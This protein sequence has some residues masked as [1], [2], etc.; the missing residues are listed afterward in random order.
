MNFPTPLELLLDP[1]SLTV[2]GMF[3][4]LY[5]WEK[6]FPRNKNLPSVKYATVRGLIAFTFFFYLNSYLPMVTDGYLAEYQM[7]D[8][9]GFPLVFQVLIGLFTYQLF[10]YG[11]HRSMHRSDKLWKVFHQMH[12]SSERLDIP[13]TFYFSPMDMIGFTLLGSTVFALFMGVSPQAITV[14]ILSLNFLSIFQHAN[15]RTPQWLGYFIQRP[16]QHAIHHERGVHKYN[17]SDFPVYDL[18]FGTF[19]NP[20]VFDGQ[21]GFYDGASAR[22]LEMIM[23]KD[24]SSDSGMNSEDKNGVDSIH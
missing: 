17:Y 16:E 11:W 19:S 3:I 15:I 24:V 10:L 2:I 6:L 7:M 4:A 5:G 1:I 21:N 23:F 13:S 20:E 9:S 8:L 12:H 18:I 22:V 14:I